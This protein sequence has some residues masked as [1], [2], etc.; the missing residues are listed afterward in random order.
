MDSR[1]VRL[2]PILFLFASAGFARA[3]NAY[4]R[5]DGTA[6]S[7]LGYGLPDD[8]CWMQWFDAVGG[9]D[10]ITAVQ[11]YIPPSTPMG[12]PITFCVWEDPNDDGDPS[13]LVLVSTL[14]TTVQFVAPNAFVNYPLPSPGLVQGKFFVGA[15]LTEDGTM[16]P[17]ALDYS[18][19]PHIAYF[20]FSAAG[21]FDPANMNNN[22]PPTH[23]ETL[24]AG[25]H[26]VF[27][28]RATGSGD[29]PTTYCTAKT[30]ALGCIPEIGWLGVPSA[31]AGAGFLVTATNVRNRK[32][33]MLL[34][35]TAGR[36]STPFFGGTLCLA[37]PLHRTPLF[38]SGGNLA[39]QDCTGLYAFDFNAWV[40]A[41]HDPLLTEGRRVE[42]QFYMRDPGFAAPNNIGLTNGLEFVLQP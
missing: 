16:S 40:A 30:N 25:I 31:S 23:I 3:Q 11:S 26:G 35:T 9:I 42:A 19:N 7:A 41:G 13:D 12:T 39:G 1:P 24:G 29:T 38:N 10:T 4:V 34:Y 36:A 17:A 20:S 18:V 37:N 22:F 21:T 2:L 14:A 33:G 8:Y 32:N 5:D 27:L 28:L 15:F 6:D